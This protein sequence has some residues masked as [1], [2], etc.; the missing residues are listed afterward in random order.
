MNTGRSFPSRR[1]CVAPMLDWTDRHARY[2]FRLVSRHAWLYTEMVTTSALLHGDAERHLR[3]DP[4]EHPVALQLGGS[5]PVALAECARMGEAWGYDEINLNVGCP[6]DRVQGGA[7]GACLMATPERVAECIL[8]MRDAVDLPVTVKHRI[9]IDQQDDWNDLI[10]FVDIVH[11]QGGCNT[12]IVHARKAW[13]D[14][15]SPKENR[16]IP[17]LMYDR[18]HRLK[19]ER[20]HL[21]I[22]INGGLTSVGA[23]LE[24]LEFVDGA[25]LGRAVYHAPML[26]A[27]VD[28]LFYGDAHAVPDAFE[29]MS[30]YRT[31]IVQ[32]L[33]AGTALR[34]MTRHLMGVFHGLPGA[35]AWRRI[36]STEGP[37]E[38]AGIEVFDRALSA[39]SQA[40]DRQAG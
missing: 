25:M 13:L 12:F 11:E 21:E 26:L 9:G 27:D 35:R 29:V 39:V 32:E 40:A 16:E 20:P 3:F 2:L 14:G 6:S 18:V 5:D 30:C 23:A 36:L 31:Y 4:A 34:H 33:E 15:L 28:R 37:C 8:A 38:G 22:I 7:F 17:P 24:H 10:R 1:F 19:R